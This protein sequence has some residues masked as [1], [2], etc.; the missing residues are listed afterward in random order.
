MASE[1][2]EKLPVTAVVPLRGENADLQFYILIDDAS[3]WTLA[4]QLNDLRQFIDA[5]PAS[6]SIGVGYLHNGIVQMVAKLTTDHGAA[7]KAVRL[8][9][10]GA[11]SPWLSLSELIKKWPVSAA[12]REVLM[13]TSGADPLGDMG[14]MPN[15]YLDSAIM[16][17][18]RAGVIVYGIY[19]PAEGHSGHSFWR[20]NWDQSH[21]GELADETGGEA[22]MLGFGPP[23][24]IQPYLTDLAAH[25][26]HQYRVGFEAKAD[27]KAG[28][29]AVRITT[30]VPN[31]EVVGAGRVYVPAQSGTQSGTH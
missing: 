13:V 20:M 11:S 10:G 1:G 21:L 6:T 23:V 15:P 19:V 18:Q 30:E 16:D 26:T 22:Y 17:A 9:R 25:L 14:A 31:A 4:S 8:P 24:S 2:K 3:N 27:I 5:Q 28:F 29:R 12:R 7:A